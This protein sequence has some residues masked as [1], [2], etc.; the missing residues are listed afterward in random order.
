MSIDWNELREK[1]LK[2]V[3][4][5]LREDIESLKMEG[6]IDLNELWNSIKSAW[7]T[8]RREYA[9]RVDRGVDE[10]IRSRFKLAQLMIATAVHS[11]G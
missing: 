7:T 9:P 2:D 6:G 11:K 5:V 10:S 3:D 4:F 1:V 8:Y